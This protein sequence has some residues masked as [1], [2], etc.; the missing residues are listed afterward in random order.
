MEQ[1]YKN[2]YYTNKNNYIKLETTP[3]FREYYNPSNNNSNYLKTINN[4]YSSYNDVV[5]DVHVNA[6]YNFTYGEITSDGITFLINHLYDNNIY[7]D[8]FLD[9]G[10]GKGRTVFHMAG[11][12]FIKKSVGVEIVPKRHKFAVNNFRDIQHQYP[13]MAKKIILLN[14]DFLNIDFKN[15]FDQNSSLFIW[16]SNLCFTQD[17]NNKILSHII[18]NNNY[19]IVLCC[20]R[21]MSSCEKLILQN[22]L[23]VKMSWMKDSNV[24]VYLLNF[25]PHII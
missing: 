12:N 7:F 23:H 25:P 3:S 13:T 15:M 22:T 9:I 14:D 20:S 2:T 16:I 24:N 21:Q 8:N 6:D 5:G 1:Q 10:S 4:I 19:K 17:S 11:Y 18:N